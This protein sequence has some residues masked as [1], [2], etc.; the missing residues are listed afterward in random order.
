VTILVHLEPP[1]PDIR[2]PPGIKFS[3][4]IAQ[5]IKNVRDPLYGWFDIYK[6]SIRVAP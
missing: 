3:R 1:N 4:R 5:F 6:K 2:P